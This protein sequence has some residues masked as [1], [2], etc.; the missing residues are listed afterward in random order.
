VSCAKTAEPI[1]I[2]IG[3]LNWVI[4]WVQERTIE[5]V[6]AAMGRDTFDFKGV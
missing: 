5:G 1:E 6:D 2:Q 3:M 4:G